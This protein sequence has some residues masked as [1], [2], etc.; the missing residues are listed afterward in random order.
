[1]SNRVIV[2]ID[3]P[4]ASGKS[5]VAKQVAAVLGYV[6]VDS[7]SLYRGVTWKAIR[8]KIDPAHAHELIDM[9]DRVDIR[10][11]LRGQSVAFTMDGLDPLGE[12]RSGEVQEKVSAVSAVPEVRERVVAWLRGMVRFGN[13]VMEG[14]DIGSAVFPDSSFRFYVDADPMVRAQRRHAE[15]AARNENVDLQ[16]VFQSLKRR[17]QTDSTRKVAPLTIPPGALV[18]DTTK[19]TV[20]EVAQYIVRQVTETGRR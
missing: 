15:L 1:M 8:D 18:V 2:A 5:T 16:S 17:D 20:E 14:R 12:L 11:F 13:L 3:G 4:S 6:Y 19:M 9:I 10:F 7:G